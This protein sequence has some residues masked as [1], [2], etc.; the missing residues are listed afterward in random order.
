M[1]VS[2]FFIIINI[3]VSKVIFLGSVATLLIQADGQN[4]ANAQACVATGNNYADFANT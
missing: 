1:S 2:I 4:S 3:I